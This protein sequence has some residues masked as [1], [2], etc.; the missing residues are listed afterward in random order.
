MFR[1]VTFR[2][3][4]IVVFGD[5][6]IT[7]GTVP[8]DANGQATYSTTTLAAGSHSIMASYSG[9]VNNAFATVTSVQEVD[10]SASPVPA[11]MLSLGM[12]A[13]LCLGLMGTGVRYRDTSWR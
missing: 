11:P 6:A 10:A 2:V 1:R 8:L 7:L 13:L 4:G 9:D 3:P 5:R 12:L